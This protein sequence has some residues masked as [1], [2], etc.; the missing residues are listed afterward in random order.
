MSNLPEI[1][2]VHILRTPGTS[3]KIS[4]E[5]ICYYNDRIVVIITNSTGVKRADV[6]TAD[7]FKRCTVD[8]EPVKPEPTKPTGCRPTEHNYIQVHEAHRNKAFCSRCGHA[9]SLD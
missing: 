1:G 5:V 7:W 2:S 6:Y 8:V 9:I 3:E 4:A